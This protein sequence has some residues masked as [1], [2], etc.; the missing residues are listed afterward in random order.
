MA[1]TFLRATSSRNSVYGTLTGSPLG[2]SSR[3]RKKLASTTSRN[4]SH[5]RRG[6][7]FGLDDSSPDAPA[8][9]GGAPGRSGCGTGARGRSPILVAIS[10]SS[11]GRIRCDALHGRSKRA[12]GR[13]HARR[14]LTRERLDDARHAARR[15]AESNARIRG[16]YGPGV[17]CGKF[18]GS[19]V[20]PPEDKESLSSMRS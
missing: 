17:G 11:S 5:V 2:T 7:I 8:F 14:L 18:G 20:V 3:T 6:G 9:R 4:V 1:S 10:L 16:R 19:D 13:T 12:R 15:F